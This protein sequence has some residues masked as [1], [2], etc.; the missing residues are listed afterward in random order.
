[1]QGLSSKGFILLLYDSLPDSAPRKERNKIAQHQFVQFSQIVE[2]SKVIN[3]LNQSDIFLM[4]GLRAKFLDLPDMSLKCVDLSVAHLEGAACHKCHMKGANFHSAHLEKADLWGANL[5]GA[6]LGIA[7]LEGADLWDTHLEGADLARANLEGANLYRT[8]LEG[9]DLRRAK[10]DDNIK[11]ATIDDK[12]IFS[13]GVRLQYF[14]VEEPDHAGDQRVSPRRSTI[15]L[16]K[17]NARR[18]RRIISSRPV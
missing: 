3:A 6:N 15:R 2:A 18:W 13:P 9:A 8:R 11:G 16:Y 7:H 5:E 10:F 12:T 14:G 1:M 17:K 4:Q